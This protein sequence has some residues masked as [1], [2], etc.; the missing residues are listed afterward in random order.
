MNRQ[1]YPITPS[2]IYLR[3]FNLDFNFSAC[4]TSSLL[5][6]KVTKPTEITRSFDNENSFI[7]M[8]NPWARSLRAPDCNKSNT[9]RYTFIEVHSSIPLLPSLTLKTQIISPDVDNIP[10]DKQHVMSMP[11]KLLS[12]VCTFVSLSTRAYKL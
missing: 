5:R 2:E 3:L 11:D 8:L 4:Q 6:T 7:K 12:S 9:R 10:G 1:C